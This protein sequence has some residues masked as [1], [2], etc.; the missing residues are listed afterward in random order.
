[1]VKKRHKVL[2]ISLAVMCALGAVA[3]GGYKW[4]NARDF[5]IAGDIV[6]HSDSGR[7]EI[8]LTFHDGPSDRTPEILATG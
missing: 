8:A 5:Q 4:M 6:S 3:F 7:K 2:W 1:M